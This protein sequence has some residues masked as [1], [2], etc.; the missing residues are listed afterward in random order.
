MDVC[1]KAL[2]GFVCAHG[3]SFELLELAE[4]VIDQ[5]APFVEVGIE[6]QGRSAPWMLCVSASVRAADF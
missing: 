4:E 1:A 2:I 6:R 3:D 5:V